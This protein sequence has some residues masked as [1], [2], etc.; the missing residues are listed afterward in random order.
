MTRIEIRRRYGETRRSI[1]VVRSKTPI[2]P[3]I[4]R[5]NTFIEDI[6]STEDTYTCSTIHKDTRKDAFISHPSQ[7]LITLCYICYRLL[8]K[9]TVETVFYQQ[10]AWMYY[11]TAQ[12]EEHVY[13]I[14][15]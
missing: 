12:N 14:K 13:F 15:K 7:I 2:V 3:L 11:K 6:Y 4:Q 1:T 5:I 8:N 9:E 10:W